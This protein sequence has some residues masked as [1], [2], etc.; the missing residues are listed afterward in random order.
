M[1]EQV[2]DDVSVED[3]SAA[4]SGVVEYSGMCMLRFLQ[5]FPF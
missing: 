5:S 3:S 4:V 2:S 1:D